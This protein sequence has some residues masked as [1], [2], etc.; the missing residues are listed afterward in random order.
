MTMNEGTASTAILGDEYDE[1]LREKLAKALREMGAVLD[2]HDWSVAG[3]QEIDSYS[4][5]IAD[6]HLLVEAETFVGLSIS[7]S[8]GLVDEVMAHLAKA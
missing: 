1:Q 8:R 5:T 6:Q 3:S 4:V 7:G 2:G